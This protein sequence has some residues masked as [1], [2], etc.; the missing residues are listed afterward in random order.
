MIPPS[1]QIRTNH[2]TPEISRDDL[3][4]I[5]EDTSRPRTE[6][7]LA[8]SALSLVKRFNSSI[9]REVQVG[10]NV[11]KVAFH[12]IQTGNQV[13]EIRERFEEFKDNTQPAQVA[14]LYVTEYLR[15]Q[16][17]APAP[18]TRQPVRSNTVS[19]TQSGRSLQQ[20]R[21]DVESR[22]YDEKNPYP[23]RSLL[24]S[25]KKLSKTFN[26]T[27]PEERA[28]IKE[29]LALSLVA[30][31]VDVNVEGLK[32]HLDG[33]RH[34]QHGRLEG[35]RDVIREYSKTLLPNNSTEPE[36]SAAPMAQYGQ[37]KAAPTMLP[38][39][40]VRDQARNMKTL[41]HQTAEEHRQFGFTINVGRDR[42]NLPN[43]NFSVTNDQ[44]GNEYVS[45]GKVHMQYG[46]VLNF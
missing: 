8:K 11:F 41:I 34:R 46:G 38:D 45:H 30:V 19:S 16:D 7:D 29:L 40:S 22:Y 36:H 32:K 3:K 42:E 12:A 14:N 24:K 37:T 21:E 17:S 27:V 44:Q 35:T 4:N 15:R 33:M 28:L 23:H 25:A 5:K 39:M 20:L 43:G 6:R 1:S 31:E 18:S 13:V 2:Y 9:P 10:K 26:E